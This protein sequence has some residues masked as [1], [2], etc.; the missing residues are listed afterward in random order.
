M[1]HHLKRAADEIE[2]ARPKVPDR[3]KVGFESEASQILWLYRTE[4]T[5]A[6][7]FESCRLRDALGAM[8][9]TPKP[10]Q[11]DEAKKLFDRWTIVLAD[12][13]ENAKAAIPIMDAD[14]R[15]DFQF[16]GD[17]TFSPGG[18][19]LRAKVALVEH[20]LREYL[21]ARWAAYEKALQTTPATK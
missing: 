1:E 8:W 6:N 21:P 14:V 9:K 4:R 10:D 13:L 15:L 7:F 12:E 11:R 19:M 2:D 3:C 17:H 18:K 16:F 5:Q 20:E